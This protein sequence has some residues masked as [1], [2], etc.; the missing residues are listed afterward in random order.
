MKRKKKTQKLQA[1][2]L[3][4]SVVIYLTDR[5][6]SK[7]SCLR[8]GYSKVAR[9][10]GKGDPKKQDLPMVEDHPAG[11]QH[12]QE[13]VETYG[14]VTNNIKRL[15]K[16][17]RISLPETLSPFLLHRPIQMRWYIYTPFLPSNFLLINFVG[18]SRVSSGVYFDSTWFSS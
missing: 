8:N 15:I 2:N 4:R 7:S 1:S 9:V 13:T 11:Q 17:F 16:E 5:E 10:L 18:N 6:M 12:A 3:I 14:T